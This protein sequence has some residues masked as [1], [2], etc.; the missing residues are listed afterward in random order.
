MHNLIGQ[1]TI[2]LAALAVSTGCLRVNETT[3]LPPD[4][5]VAANAQSH[6][7]IFRGKYYLSKMC[8]EM[9]NGIRVMA[10]FGICEIIE[11]KQGH[12]TLETLRGV[13]FPKDDVVSGV[14][15]FRWKL[16]DAQMAELQKAQAG[17]IRGM[18]IDCT[19]EIIP[20]G[21]LEN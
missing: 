3:D 18:W 15:T 14:Y 10:D 8:R 5:G 12:L 20:T 9:G 16:S 6:E 17:G 11:V 19:L 7:I 13:H 4:P 21:G 2:L 1:A